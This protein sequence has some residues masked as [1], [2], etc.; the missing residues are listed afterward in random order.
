MPTANEIITES[1]RII[2]AIA[3][4]E[5]P[6]SSE[7][8]DGLVK[9]NDMLDIFSTEDLVVP[10]ITRELFTCTPSQ[11]IHTLGS[12][13]DFDT[14]R[15]L[16]VKKVV[17]QDPS[18]SNYELPIRIR[19]MEEYAG[20]ASKQTTSEIPESVYIDNAYPLMN[21]YF[22]PIPSEAIK[23]IL[24]TDKVIQN[25]ATGA[26]SMSLPP[27]YSAM[28]KYNLAQFLAPEYGL[29]LSPEAA[30]VAMQSKANIKRQNKR[31]RYL[32]SDATMAVAN[33]PYDWR[34][35]E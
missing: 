18:N 3:S 24:W 9:L 10:G 20:I 21:L 6:S 7:L 19:Q 12:G 31:P 14:T 11:Q 30:S 29:S 35:G 28:L 13:G 17:Y 16:E 33:K 23:V 2:G 27:G 22:W 8:A 5:T 15:P 4:N 34:T 1:L 32:R 25:F 26:T